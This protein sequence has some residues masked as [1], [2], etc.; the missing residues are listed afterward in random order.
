MSA[1]N[2]GNSANSGPASNGGGSTSRGGM[3]LAPVAENWEDES[4]SSSN[5]SDDEIDEE[6]KEE[7]DDAQTSLSSAVNL[8]PRSSTSFMGGHVRPTN[9]IRA[10]PPTP[11]A[12]SRQ[13]TT[14]NFSQGSSS[15]P[16][17]SKRPEKQT[18]VASRMIA[19]SLGVRVNRT[20]QQKA[21]DRTVI[22][23]EKSRREQEKQAEENAKKKAK[24]DADSVWN[25]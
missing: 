21:Y 25:K 22:A 12:I 8:S 3:P 9:D 6:E 2:Q 16:N 19:N 17:Y 10:P 11:A 24:E 13:S 4:V 23:N 15:N 20:E 18:A 7:N 14:S 1:T 5:P